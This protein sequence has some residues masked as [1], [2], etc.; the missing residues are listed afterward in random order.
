[1]KDEAIKLLR[2]MC[3][4]QHD[5]IVELRGLRA[6]L[7]ER[8]IE[9]TSERLVNLKSPEVLE[10]AI[11]LMVAAVR[12]GSGFHSSEVA[13]RVRDDPALF[14]ALGSIIGK[15]AA[16]NPRKLGDILRRAAATAACGGIRITRVKTLAAGALWSADKVVVTSCHHEVTT[17]SVTEVRA[18]VL[19]EPAVKSGA[20]E[21]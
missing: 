14:E 11:P 10:K 21:K 12:G 18:P 20:S 15:S 19:I 5:L 7:A 8:R 2:K 3:D 9:S 6:D 16:I 13:M 1:M 17:N 4:Q